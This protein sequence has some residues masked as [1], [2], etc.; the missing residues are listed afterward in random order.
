LIYLAG[1]FAQRRFSP[2]SNWRS[3]NDD[4]DIIKK[5]LPWQFDCSGFEKRYLAFLEVAAQRLVDYFWADIEAVAEALLNHETL[6]GREILAVINETRSKRRASRRP[7]PLTRYRALSWQQKHDV[8][9]AF[10]GRA[11]WWYFHNKA[12]VR[13]AASIAR[14][15]R[16]IAA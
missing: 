11:P 13:E 8:I 1:P 16:A 2:R 12:A 9:E 10:A 6:T 3:G 4:F 7:H 14:T 15:T 5:R